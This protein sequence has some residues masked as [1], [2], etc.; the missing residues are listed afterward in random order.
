[1]RIRTAIHIP[2]RLRAVD[3]ACLWAEVPAPLSSSRQLVHAPSGVLNLSVGSP[4]PPKAQA[5]EL[6]AEHSGKPNPWSA[7]SASVWIFPTSSVPL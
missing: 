7:R 2:T 6:Y 3:L 1:M 5:P 4:P